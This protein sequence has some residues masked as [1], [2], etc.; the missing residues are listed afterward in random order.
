M[1]SYLL[2]RKQQVKVE[3]VD[4]G[5]FF[6]NIGVG[7]GTILGPTLFKIYIMDLHLHTNLFCV[8]FADDSSFEGS[9]RSRDEVEDLVNSELEKIADWF[10]NNRL[11]LHPDKSRYIV[12][13]RDKLISIKLNNTEVM[14]CGYGLQEESVKL[15][16]LHIDENLDWS[17][18]I[19]SIT[20]KIAKGS[21]LL[22]RYKKKLDNCSKKNNL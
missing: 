18:H 20:K 19:N 2:D 12:H 11:T 16:G 21:Y 1:K 22:W 9:G 4:G 10:K 13:S 7:Q 14:R 8:K 15:L 3:G 5:V 6:V 17:V